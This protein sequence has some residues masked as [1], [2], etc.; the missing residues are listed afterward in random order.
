MRSPP[1]CD[2]LADGAPITRGFWG[3]L[4]RLPGKRISALSDADL[5]KALLREPGR[6]PR[7]WFAGLGQD[8][9]EISGRRTP[10]PN[11]AARGV[12]AEPP[13]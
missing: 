1:R 8:A 7:E 4:P 13:A 11:G 2:K 5:P 12:R 3:G 6:F 10:A 9:I